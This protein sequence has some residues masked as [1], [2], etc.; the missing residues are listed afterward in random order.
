MRRALSF[1]VAA[2]FAAILSTGPSAGAAPAAPVT[3]NYATVDGIKIFYREAGD[4]QKPTIVLLHGFPSSSHMFRDL[5]PLLS[6]NFHLI[7]PDYVG[8]G[9]SEAPPAEKFTATF[10]S[11]TAVTEQLLGQLG[12]TKVILY[13]QDF[14]GPVGMRVAT[15][16]PD[17]VQGLIIQNTP[18]SEDSWAPAR[19]KAVR[20]LAGPVTPEKRAA[21]QS[22]VTVETDLLFYQKGARNPAQLNPDAWANDAYTLNNPESRRIMTDLLLDLPLTLDLYPKW[23]A[24]LEKEQPETLVV[25]GTNDTSNAPAGAEAVKRF[26]PKAEVHLYDTGHFAL[27]EDAPDIALQITKTFAR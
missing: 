18:I 16:H 2:V 21:A 8:M 3:Y 7:A 22:L 13:M 1:A 14:G 6:S 19:L 26:V 25:W 11:I 10:D 17:W 12:D 5:I 27:E 23:R 15:H 20:A 4:P 9:Y 24:Y